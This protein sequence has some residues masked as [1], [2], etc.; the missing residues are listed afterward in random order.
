MQYGTWPSQFTAKILS[1]DL[2]I[3]DIQWDNA[4]ETLVWREERDDK[5]VLVAQSKGSAPRDLTESLS[6]KASVGY[7]GGDFTVSANCVYF[8]AKNGRI[9]SQ[10]LSGGGA[11]AITPEFG[12]ATSPKVSSD[13]QW[14]A[15]VYHYE[16]QDGL[17]I[18]DTKGKLWPIKIFSNT[19]FIMQ[20]IWHPKGLYLAAITWNH[21]QMPWDGSH[22]RLFKWNGNIS[23]KQ[24][25]PEEIIAG[26]IKTSI[27]QPEFSPDGQYISYIGDESG[28]GQIYVYDLSKKTHQ[29]ITNKNA[30][31][32]APAWIQGMRTYS[33]RGKDIIFIRHEQGKDSLWSYT[34]LNKKET[35][36]STFEDYTAL[37]QI[38][39]SPTG[40]IALIASSSTIPKRIISLNQQH[41]IIKR[42][43]TENYINIFKTKGFFI[44]WQG[45]DE[46]EVYGLYYPPEGTFTSEGTPP[47][48]VEIHGGPTSHRKLD[49]YNNIKFFTTRGFAYL[50]VNYRGSTGYGKAYMNKLY[51]NWGIYDVE[52]A[53]AGASY[54]AN[55]GLADKSKFIVMGGSAGGFSVLHSL[56]TKPRFY[57]AGICMYGVSNH[58]L[59]AA[60]TH[61]FEKHYLDILLGPLPQNA[62]TYHQRSPYFHADKIVDALAIYQGTEDI[63]VPKNQS[64]CIY[65]S[66]KKR[67][68]PCEYH[69][70]SGEGH[71][72][73]KAK[74]IEH[75]YNSIY[76]FLKQYVLYT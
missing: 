34:P 15:Y 59:L 30:E 28:W 9:Y 55:K 31:H 24:V 33:W 8:V 41:T 44:A 62:E 18:V 65:E 49:Y 23:L 36:I 54:L 21:P 6:I 3:S 57:K 17:A 29:S 39:V 40:D 38:S 13:N 32:G 48:I 22:L 69:V 20:P 76:S 70:Y 45:F 43:N 56:I 10:M 50:Q 4:S 74:T 53:A 51:G 5:G 72:W 2:R 73:R 71:G 64:D 47:L 7:G 58:F 1:Q 27:F 19:D 52:D 67:C 12:M 14:I 63:V 16:G 46:E 42:T 75:F 68:V 66:L 26:D 11:I 61:K 35:K 60:D 37:T 25:I